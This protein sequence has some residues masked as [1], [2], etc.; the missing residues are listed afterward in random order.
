MPPRERGG[1]ARHD[2]LAQKDHDSDHDQPEHH[3]LA[4]MRRGQRFRQK[5]RTAAPTRNQAT[6]LTRPRSESV[7]DAPSRQDDAA[8][9]DRRRGPLPKVNP[10]TRLEALA[11]RVGLV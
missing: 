6:V 8:A 7:A 2:A 10:P 1:D 5:I 11:R 4:I 9:I 3:L